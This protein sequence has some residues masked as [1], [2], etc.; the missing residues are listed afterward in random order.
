MA[1]A[2]PKLP[3]TTNIKPH[4]RAA[5]W[6]KNLVEENDKMLSLRRRAEDF[7]SKVASEI[8]KRKF[9]GQI[10]TDFTIFP[11]IEMKKVR[12]MNFIFLVKICFYL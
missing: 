6:R 3:S 4:N 10:Q 9:G 11:T 8:V 12:I 1:L 2:N 7:Q 5:A